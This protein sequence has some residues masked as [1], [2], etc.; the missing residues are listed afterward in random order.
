MR[1][2]FACL[3]WLLILPAAAKMP[4]PPIAEKRPFEVVIHGDTLR[5]SWHWLRD[6]D[7]PAL[8][9]VLKAEKKYAASALQPSRRLAKNLYRE[10]RANTVQTTVS[11]PYL[12]RD[13][14]YYV[15]QSSRDAYPIHCR[16]K[17]MPDSEEK[18]ILDENKLA[19]GLDFFSLGEFSVSPDGKL[20]AYS[21]DTSGNEDHRLY[22]KDLMSGITRDT[23]I[24]SVSECSWMEDSRR[25]ILTKMNP[26]FQTDTAWC[27][28]LSA[29]PP[30]LLYTETD[31]AF[32][33]GLYY[34]SDKE[35]IFLSSSSKDSSEAR[36]LS[37]DAANPVWTLISPRATGI[38]YWPDHYLDRLLIQS[39]HQDPDGA[40]YQCSLENTGLDS[41]STLVSGESIA[42]LSGFI[43]CDTTLVLLSRPDGFERL[44][45][46]SL[47]TGEKLYELSSGAI[48]DLGFWV[49]SD[50]GKPYFDYTRESELMPWSV[51]RHDLASNTDS[52]MYRQ[53]TPPGFK[54]EE[55]ATTMLL[56]TATDGSKVPVR[57]KY[58][59]S[60][61][62]SVPHPVILS[63]YGAYGDSEDPYFSAGDLPLLKRGVVLATA[64]PRGGGEFGSAWYEGGKMLNKMNSFTD[65]IACADLLLQQGITTSDQLAIS[66]GSAGGLLIGA[67]LNLA[68]QKFAAAALD[69]PFVD[70][71]NTMLDPDLPLTV[72]E[73]E[74]WGNPNDPQYYDYI[75]SYSPYD[76][77]FKAPYPAI[78]I[79]TA[80][81]DTR[82]GYWEGLK[83]A[84][85]LRQN[86]SSGQAVIFRLMEDE[87]HSGSGDRFKSLREYTQ[88]LAWLL[89]QIGVR[90]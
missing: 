23:G 84:Q 63:G 40:I 80:W 56:A 73:Y 79:S 3:A 74:E 75:R 18:V 25:L 67:V 68:P 26:R 59:R 88:G 76:N 10:M 86:S 60:L 17:N 90:S 52:L 29:K 13:Y 31:P 64:H 8:P 2:I 14:L 82:V 37:S 15:R 69:V 7:D 77:V 28:D 33:L 34:T 81:Q 87:G 83:L 19:R 32:D 72:Q 20:L 12:Y 24:V 35:L 47:F 30:E 9:R 51:F 78:C 62:L 1:Q 42:P 41:W 53:Q 50:P 16:R 70:V 6:R 22:I 45:V 39:D 43:V 54:A 38:Q 44:A 71:L 85:K 66:G 89:W 65:F 48:A 4:A 58:L 21:A 49:N 11:H 5:D 46:H 57:L 55:F 36:Y 61:D 27:W